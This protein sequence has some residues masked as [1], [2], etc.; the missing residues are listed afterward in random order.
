M[1]IDGLYCQ[2]VLTSATLSEDVDRLKKL[3][4]NNPV[5][6]KLSEPQLPDS[7]QL[8]QVKEKIFCFLFSIGTVW[9][10][11]SLQPV[12]WIRNY[13]FRIWIRGSV[14]MNY[15]SGPRIWPDQG[16]WT[17]MWSFWKE[18]CC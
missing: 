10:A 13:F 16:F 9:K 15:G 11:A 12:L 14:I 1:L 5:V 4:L 8:T 6:L 2:A 17:F 7:S 3:V 18:I